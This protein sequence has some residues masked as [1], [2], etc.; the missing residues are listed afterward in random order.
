MTNSL[1]SLMPQGG[2]SIVLSVKPQYAELILAGSKTVE[3]RRV[4]AAHKVDTIA[5]YASSPIQKLVGVVKVA[6]VVRAK[7]ETLWSYCSKRGGGLSKAELLAYLFGKDAGFAVLLT[8]A[9]RFSQGVA[10]KKVIKNFSPPQSF[11]Y[12]TQSEAHKLEQLISQEKVRR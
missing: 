10:P 1:K 6:E 4:W 11:R 3:F 8:G 2:R 7:P 9:R 5:I 12:L